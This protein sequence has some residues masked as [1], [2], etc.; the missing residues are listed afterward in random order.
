MLF[1]CKFTNNNLIEQYFV[2]I[3]EIENAFWS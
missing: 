2:I 3:I 1:R